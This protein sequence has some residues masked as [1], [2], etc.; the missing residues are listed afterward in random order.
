M[1][2]SLLDNPIWNSLNS[3]HRSLATLHKSAGRF[4]PDVSPLVGM[5][6]GS[7]SSFNDLALV[8][9]DGTGGGTFTAYPIT[10]P[11]GWEA[12]QRVIDQMV[13]TE[14]AGVRTDGV[15]LLGE[16]DVP[17]MLELTAA[18]EPGPFGSKTI[19]FGRYYGIRMDDGRLAAMAGE[20]LA[21][22]RFVEISAVCTRA[23]FRGRGYAS[24]LVSLIAARILSVGKV[25]FLH[26][27]T[28]NEARLVY[29]KIGFSVRKPMHVTAVKKI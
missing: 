21:L 16:A 6:D 14:M 17:D 24:S 3:D 28:E 23:E 4:S 15:R 2:F 27:K 8:L 7:E 1:N 18:T 9:S 12:R 29:E 19:S 13:C 5:L 26:V 10:V 22:D 20:R 11:A 25:P